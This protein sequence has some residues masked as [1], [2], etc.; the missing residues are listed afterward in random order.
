MTQ[1]A[2]ASC[3]APHGGIDFI[4][5]VGH[6]N[7]PRRAGRETRCESVHE[8]TRRRSGS[9]QDVTRK[10]PRSLRMCGLFTLHPLSLLLGCLLLVVSIPSVEGHAKRSI[11]QLTPKEFNTLVSSLNASQSVDPVSPFSHLSKILI[12]R[13]R[14]CSKC[15]WFFICSHGFDSWYCQQHTGPKLYLDYSSC[16]EVAHRRRFIRRSDTLWQQDFHQCNCHQGS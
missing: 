10:A 2:K 14:R 5:V 13:S 6:W 4:A 8:C 9:K 15:F 7:R 12:P 16:F 1:V 11:S 3:G